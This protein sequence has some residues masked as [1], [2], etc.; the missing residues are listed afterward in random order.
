MVSPAQYALP[1]LVASNIS[2]IIKSRNYD[3]LAGG[4]GTRTVNMKAISMC[5]FF[6]IQPDNNYNFLKK[7]I[8]FLFY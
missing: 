6:C 8:I 7:I 4:Y 5:R 3:I 2:F 1:G